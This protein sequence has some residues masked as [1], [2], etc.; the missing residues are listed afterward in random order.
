VRVDRE[1][2]A[3]PSIAFA[4]THIW[5]RPGDME[6][7]ADMQTAVE[8][9]AYAA[10][11]AGAKLRDLELPP[12]FEEALAAQFTIQDFEAF[13]ALAW[14]FDHHRER[15]SPVLRAQLEKAALIDFDTYDEAR[16][17]ARRARQMLANLLADNEVILTPSATGVA[18]EGL[19]ATGNPIF[20]RLWSVL[21]APCVNVPGIVD[22][23]GLPLGVQIVGR[24]A[25]DR[26]TL[27]A[28]YFLE[29]TLAAAG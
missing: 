11:A 4:R 8:Q 27:A 1:E 26:G 10:E 25:R 16:R 17:I 14:E 21:G 3:A 7:S 2:P 5:S 23:S 15:L 13:R 18:P 19:E 6:A 20:N 29:R 9:A 24:F 12:L 28:A 22:D